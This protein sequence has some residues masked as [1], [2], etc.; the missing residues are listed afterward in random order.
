MINDDEGPICVS[1]RS[2]GRQFMP[3]FDRGKI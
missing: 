1:D 2:R 3:K